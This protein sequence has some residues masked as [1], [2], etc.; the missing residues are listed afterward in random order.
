MYGEKHKF[1]QIQI[2]KIYYSNVTCFIF[3]LLLAEQA[4]EQTIKVAGDL[5]Y[6]DTHVMDVIVMW[7]HPIWK[8]LLSVGSAQDLG[9]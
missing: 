9:I 8:H 4:V 1:H 2:K 3:S 6:H 7:Y 5:R